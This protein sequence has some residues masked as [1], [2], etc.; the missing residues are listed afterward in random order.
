MVPWSH[1]AVLAPFLRHGDLLAEKR[2]FPTSL[3]FNLL[4]RNPVEFSDKLQPKY[5]PK[6]SSKMNWNLSV[7]IM[8]FILMNISLGCLNIPARDGQAGGQ[9]NMQTIMYSVIHSKLSW[10]TISR[11]RRCHCVSF[12]WWNRHS[13]P[14]VWS[15]V[16]WLNALKLNQQDQAP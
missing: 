9:T 16:S 14:S 2:H 3:S 12:Q 13:S 6:K 5:L 8:W 15:S 10:H 7:K 1:L 11:L 4:S